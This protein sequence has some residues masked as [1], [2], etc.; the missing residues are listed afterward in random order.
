MRW[1]D[2]ATRAATTPGIVVAARIVVFVQAALWAI[3]AVVIV[4]A[5]KSNGRVLASALFLAL[6]AAVLFALAAAFARGR[7][8]VRQ[9]LLL[10][11]GIFVLFDLFPAIAATIDYHPLILFPSLAGLVLPG[12]TMGCLYSQNARRY[13]TASPRA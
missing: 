7:D 13:F 12:V 4:A 8:G 11:E 2:N 6:V 1:P 10:V 3:F 9:G 5:Y